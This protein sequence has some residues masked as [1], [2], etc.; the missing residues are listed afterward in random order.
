MPVLH[1]LPV[2]VGYVCND[3]G[4][5]PVVPLVAVAW[6]AVFPVVCP[7]PGDIPVAVRVPAVVLA[8]FPGAVAVQVVAWVAGRRVRR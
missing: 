7:G 3:H 8:A 6:V 1:G 4:A 5:S 2:I